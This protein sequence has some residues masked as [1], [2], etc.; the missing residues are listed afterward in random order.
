MSYKD[1][2]ELERLLGSF[3]N[4][5]KNHLTADDKKTLRKAMR[6]IGRENIRYADLYI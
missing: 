4:A 6:I 3:V 1:R 2:I 5:P